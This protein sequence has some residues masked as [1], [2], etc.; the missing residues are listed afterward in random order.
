MKGATVKNKKIVVVAVVTALTLFSVPVA[1][2]D[3]TFKCFVT[4][5][6]KLADERK[7][8]TLFES[9]SSKAAAEA[10]IVTRYVENGNEYADACCGEGCSA[11]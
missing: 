5:A 9:A 11:P 2:A 8:V 1:R 10:A 7:H 6:K 3:Q 4:W